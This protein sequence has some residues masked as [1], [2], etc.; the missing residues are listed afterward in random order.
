MT[1]VSC[2][3]MYRKAR[4]A[5]DGGV[6]GRYFEQLVV[7]FLNLL[8]A[9][10][11]I[12]KLT[13]EV[14]GTTKSYPIPIATKSR[15][16][17]G[18]MTQQLDA[19]PVPGAGATFVG[20]PRNPN[21]PFVDAL[22]LQ[23]DKA[24][25][26]TALLFQ[27]TAASLHLFL[28]GSSESGPLAP[29]G[30]QGQQPLQSGVVDETVIAQLGKDVTVHKGIVAARRRSVAVQEA[31]VETIKSF[32]RMPAAVPDMTQWDAH[33]AAQVEWY[34]TNVTTP[35][36]DLREAKADLGRAN[37]GL[38]SANAGLESAKADL[39]DAQRRPQYKQLPLPPQV[40]ITARDAE[41]FELVPRLPSDGPW[42]V[43]PNERDLYI[44]NAHY[45]PAVRPAHQGCVGGGAEQMGQTGG[46]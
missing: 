46:R 23:R 32:M 4:N 34:R 43:Y 6:S 2:R 8:M 11:T 22:M 35:T 12:T 18:F 38:E 33:D 21:F 45:P 14:E 37:A 1:E 16:F 29:P 28:Q 42:V 25:K 5:Q 44:R 20:F 3:T 24:G 41:I 13:V 36:N 9:D 27:Y 31:I 15:G 19:M 39:R 17:V 26:L 7:Q 30:P 10:T 40:P